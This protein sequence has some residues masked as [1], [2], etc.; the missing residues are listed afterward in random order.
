MTA[1]EHKE[2]LEEL[3]KYSKELA[4]SK[5]N[6]KSFFIEAGIYTPTGRLTK[7]YSSTEPNIGY[8]QNRSQEKTENNLECTPSVRD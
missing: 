6:L 3:R 2:Y 7:I 4:K 5:E 1:K 8:V